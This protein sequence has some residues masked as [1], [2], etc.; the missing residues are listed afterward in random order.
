MAGVRYRESNLVDGEK[1]TDVIRK[2]Y[3][4]KSNIRTITGVRIFFV[5]SSIRG[6]SSVCRPFPQALLVVNRFQITR[7]YANR[8]TSRSSTIQ[9]LFLPFVLVTCVFGRGRCL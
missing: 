5:D 6:V 7:A 1:V 9:I 3:F 4:Q 8:C 2:H